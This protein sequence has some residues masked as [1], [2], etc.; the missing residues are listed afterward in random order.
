MSATEV[1]PGLEREPEL[2]FPLAASL[3]VVG[4]NTP[5]FTS[6]V[7]ELVQRHVAGLAADTVYG[8]LSRDENYLSLVVPI[9]FQNRGQYD[10]VY[11]ELAASEW[12]IMVL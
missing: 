5:E 11:A 1:D 4:R 8:R 9:L 7:I 2:L 6:V 3:R 12:V 10:A